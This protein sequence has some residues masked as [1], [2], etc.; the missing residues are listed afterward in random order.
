MAKITVPK[1]QEMKSAGEKIAMVTA[2][3]FTFSQVVAPAPPGADLP[4]LVLPAEDLP[5]R[6]AATEDLSDTGEGVANG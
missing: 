4:P 3:A 2:T 6:S 1:L 5:L